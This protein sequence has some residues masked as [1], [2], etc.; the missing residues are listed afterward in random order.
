[1]IFQKRSRL[2]PLFFGVINVW[3]TENNEEPELSCVSRR[4]NCTRY[5]ER[6]RKNKREKHGRQDV[7]V[8]HCS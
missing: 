7:I 2:V 5:R 3:K 6:L 8:P 4:E 1:M